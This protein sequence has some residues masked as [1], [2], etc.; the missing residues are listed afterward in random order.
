MFVGASG[1]PALARYSLALLFPLLA[2]LFTA[3]MARADR[4]PSFPLFSLA[5]VLVSIFG[6]TRPGL[7]AV[8]ESVLINILAIPPNFS[9]LVASWDDA[10]RIAVFVFAGSGIALLIGSVGE[11]QSRLDKERSQLSITLQSIAD[12]VI[13]TDAQGRITLMNPAAEEA[14]GHK[15]TSAAGL[16][17]ESVFK[18]VNEISR[19][20]VDSPVKKVLERGQ[21]AELAEDT[22]LLR[23]DG[24]AIAIEDSAAAIRDAR[25]DTVGAVLVFRDVTESRF[26]Q[27][28][29]I[30]S[31]KLETASKLGA[32]I[33]HETNNPLEA[34]ANLL[35]LISRDDAAS[36]TTRHLAEMAQVEIARAA[37]A[38]KRTLSLIRVERAKTKLTVSDLIDSAFQSYQSTAKNSGIRLEN[39][40]APDLEVTA[41]R[42]ELRQLVS[43]LISNAMDAMMA[44]GG[45]LRVNAEVAEQE[46]SRQVRIRFSDT[47]NGIEP[48]HLD[49][50]FEPFFTTKKDKGTGLGLWI[51]KR[52]AEDHGGELQVESSQAGSTFTV[53]L[54]QQ[55]STNPEVAEMPERQTEGILD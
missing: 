2:Y 17:V 13:A 39:E 53:L 10:M 23:P 25:G 8:T 15:F 9:L 43:N 24:T 6:G 29:L 16:P 55:C 47:G 18:I 38:S 42:N 41:L 35:F 34:L 31:E 14:T 50:I 33:A 20:T 44:S 21:V 46:E 52:V 5:V 40:V 27:K 49:R 1:R 54:P 30:R 4:G 19:T 37:E 28:A 51:A 26:L 36:E 48:A 32:T 45:V 11:L 7:V 3:P 22:V 12:A